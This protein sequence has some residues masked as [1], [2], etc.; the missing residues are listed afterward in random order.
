MA[1]ELGPG[2]PHI[3][4]DL[5]P[6]GPISRGGPY[7]AYTGFVACFVIIDNRELGIAHC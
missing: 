2:G 5:G 1:S 6:G 3:T 4:S 7:R